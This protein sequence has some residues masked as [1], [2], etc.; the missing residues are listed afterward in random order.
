MNIMEDYWKSIEAWHNKHTGRS[1]NLRKGVSEKEIANAEKK[2]KIKFQPDFRSHLLLHDGQN[3]TENTTEWLPG[4]TFLAP[5]EEIVSQWKQEREDFAE[6]EEETTKTQL[7]GSMLKCFSHPKRIPIAGT[8]YWDGDA[9]YLDFAPGKKGFVG[10]VI[11]LYT[12]CDFVVMGNSFEHALKRYAEALQQ[13]IFKWDKKE[14][15]LYFKGEDK[16][17]NQAYNFAFIR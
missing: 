11:A 9:A 10:Q 12:E 3:H 6:F 14:E 15:I 1:L 5:L 13:G 16:Y 4:C 17:D 7:K 2:L 8:K